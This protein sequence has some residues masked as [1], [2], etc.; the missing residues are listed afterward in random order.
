MPRHARGVTRLYAL[1]SSPPDRTAVAVRDMPQSTP[2]TL[3]NSVWTPAFD[4][5]NSALLV[6]LRPASCVGSLYEPITLISRALF[7]TIIDV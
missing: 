6:K 4:Q 7:R 1:F 5:E 3:L 2:M